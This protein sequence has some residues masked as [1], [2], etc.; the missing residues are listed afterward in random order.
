M[1]LAI[2][3]CFPG[4]HQFINLFVRFKASTL[5]LITPFA[6]GWLCLPFNHCIVCLKLTLWM[7]EIL[8]FMMRGISFLFLQVCGVDTSKISS[9]DI[10]LVMLPGFMLSSTHIL[11]MDALSVFLHLF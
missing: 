4:N 1:S 7:L 2:A 8:I 9:M 6:M 5:W 11:L 3:L 10:Q